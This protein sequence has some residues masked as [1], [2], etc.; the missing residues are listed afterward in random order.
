MGPIE[1]RLRKKIPRRGAW[2]LALPGERK[3]PEEKET[4][5]ERF[6][7]KKERFGKERLGRSRHPGRRTEHGVG[8]NK[9]HSGP[10]GRLAKNYLGS[11]VKQRERGRESEQ[12]TWSQRKVVS[13]ASARGGGKQNEKNWQKNLGALGKL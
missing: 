3:H 2:N 6:G 8:P 9:I 7:T 11:C 13:G 5:T 10:I 4:Q 1:E 12:P